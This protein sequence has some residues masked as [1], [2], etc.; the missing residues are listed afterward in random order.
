[1]TTLRI[2]SRTERVET[3]G[4]YERRGYTVTKAQ[5]VFDKTLVDRH[6]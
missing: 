5:N 1:V 6:E 4:F 3:R 2:R